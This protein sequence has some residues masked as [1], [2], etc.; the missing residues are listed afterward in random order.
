[1]T[2]CSVDRSE[3]GGAA[4]CPPGEFYPHREDTHVCTGSACIPLRHLEPNSS[5]LA[6]IRTTPDFTLTTQADEPLR[7]ADLRGKVVLV[8][9]VFTTCGGSC[10]VTTHRMSQVAEAL[11]DQGLRKTT[12]SACCR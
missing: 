7:L 3:P 2:C 6:V 12:A 9:F 4:R 5:R 1:M 8:S 10:P 11:A